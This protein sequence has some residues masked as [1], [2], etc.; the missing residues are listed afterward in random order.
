[1]VCAK[2][3]TLSLGLWSLSFALALYFAAVAFSEYL[4]PAAH[5][6]IGSWHSFPNLDTPPGLMAAHI[7]S[8]MVLLLVL[9]LQ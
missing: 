1:M 3:S 8:S 7:A 9:V 5:G 2:T 6:N 4:I